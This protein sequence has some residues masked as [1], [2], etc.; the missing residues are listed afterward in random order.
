M[1]ERFTD[2]ARA[3]VVAAQVEARRLSHNSSAPSTSCSACS[4]TT[5]ALQ[6]TLAQVDVSAERVRARI[7]ELVPP[8]RGRRRQCHSRPGKSGSLEE[9]LREAVRIGHDI[10]GPEHL[11]LGS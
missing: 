9:A 11:L 5:T 2:Q 8:V 1:F 7:L 6:R 3:T 10:I 4:A